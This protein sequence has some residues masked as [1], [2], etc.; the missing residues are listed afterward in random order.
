VEQDK[1]L[2]AAAV[3]VYNTLTESKK[4]GAMAEWEGGDK[5]EC[6]AIKELKAALF[7]AVPIIGSDHSKIGTQRSDNSRHTAGLA[8]D[9]MLDS[10]DPVEKSVADDL[11][12]AFVKLHSTTL[13]TRTGTEENRFIFT[14]PDSR[15]MAERTGCSKRTRRTSRLARNTKTTST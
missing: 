14:Y 10:R 9:I 6:P 7:E 13:S 4:E 5:G 3:A 8:M 12:A 2:R 11:I 15:R 1:F